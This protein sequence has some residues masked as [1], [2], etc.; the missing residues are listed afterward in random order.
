VHCD[1]LQ[2][3]VQ[4]S[5]LDLPVVGNGDVMLMFCVSC[6]PDMAACLAGWLI[7]QAT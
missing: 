1:I 6:Q 3:A 2:D 5:Q 4:R 7:T